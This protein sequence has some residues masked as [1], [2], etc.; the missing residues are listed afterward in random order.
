MDTNNKYGWV[1]YLN[2]SKTNN[3]HAELGSVGRVVSIKGYRYSVFIDGELKAGQLSGALEFNSTEEYKP[4]VGD[5]VEGLDFDEMLVIQS[6]LQPYRQFYRVAQGG[7]SKQIMASNVDF[8]L[9]VQGL[10]D[11]FNLMRMERY[12]VQA[13]ACGVEPI[14]V[15]TKADL[16][17][18]PAEYVEQVHSIRKVKVFSISMYDKS[19]VDT[20]FAHLQEAQTYLLAGSSGVGKSTLINKLMGADTQEVQE[21]STAN[22]KGRHTTTSSELMVLDN[23]A[24][25]IDT[26]GM[27]SFAVGT[28]G[29]ERVEGMFPEIEAFAADCKYADCSHTTEVAC[30]VLKAL[31]TGDLPQTA[32][33]SYIKLTKE[34]RFHEHTLTDKKMAGKKMARAIKDVKTFKSRYK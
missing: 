20:F 34:Q 15:L 10:D 30:T 8:L 7:R 27:R 11:N 1:H 5:W 23:G 25:I 29:G 32:Y 28:D 31:R 13:I 4:K 2:K 12:I 16:V 17:D 9:I 19:S 24:I 18:S 26:P 21:V 6:R 14:V 3:N 22:N 33:N